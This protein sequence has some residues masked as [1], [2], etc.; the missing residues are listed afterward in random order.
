MICVLGKNKQKTISRQNCQLLEMFAPGKRKPETP[1]DHYYYGYIS[2]IAACTTGR[3]KQVGPSASFTPAYTR[4]EVSAKCAPLLV[5]AQA[6]VSLFRA[7]LRS[8]CDWSTSSLASK[9]HTF[10]RILVDLCVPN[11]CCFSVLMRAC[12]LAAHAEFAFRIN[13]RHYV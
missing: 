2:Y 11:G 6:T 4:H 3:Y 8:V 12:E 10:I 13:M 7:P 1:L 9:T 5:Q